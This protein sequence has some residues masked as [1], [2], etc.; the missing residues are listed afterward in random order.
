MLLETYLVQNFISFSMVPR[1]MGGLELLSEI[2]DIEYDL[3]FS[4]LK[5]NTKKYALYENIHKM[6]GK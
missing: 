6:K 4:V 3:L 1:K 2:F 5:Q